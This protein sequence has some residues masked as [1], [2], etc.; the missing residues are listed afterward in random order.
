MKRY[1]N[2]TLRAAPQRSRKGKRHPR[3][4]DGEQK[5][6]TKKKSP[7]S[8]P[9]RLCECTRCGQSSRHRIGELARAGKVRCSACGGNVVEARFSSATPEG[10]QEK[11]IPA[12][13]FKRRLQQLNALSRNLA[14]IGLDGEFLTVDEIRHYLQEKLKET[15]NS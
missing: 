9:T 12:K 10:A 8:I 7:G 15:R 11:E 13:V 14:R 2:S 3:R 1:W 5:G 4:R 6:S